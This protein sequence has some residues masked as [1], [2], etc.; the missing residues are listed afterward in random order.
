MSNKKG[1]SK[2]ALV[3]IIV[4]ILVIIAVATVLT[5]IF[6]NKSTTPTGEL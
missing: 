6:L 5:I 2:I 4:V 1:M 3:L